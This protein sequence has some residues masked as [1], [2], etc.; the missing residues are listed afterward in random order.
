MSDRALLRLQR[1]LLEYIR[2]PD[3]Q[4][5]IKY[6]D[7]NI[8]KVRAL[9]VGPVNTP[10]AF[11]MFEFTM[12]FPPEYP[13]VPP[14]VKILTT[15][16]GQ[17]RFNPNFYANGKVCLSILGTWIGEAGEQWSSAHGI[18]SILLSIQSLMTETPY[19][20]EPGYGKDAKYTSHAFQHPQAQMSSNHTDA[21]KTNQTESVTTLPETTMLMVNDS[22]N[23]TASS[24]K[25]Q[26]NAVN[27]NN[28]NNNNTSTTSIM[29]PSSIQ[30]SH[31]NTIN[32][33]FDTAA[34]TA[35]GKSRHVKL[36]HAKFK[37][38]YN[39]KIT[40]ET[41]RISVCDRLEA[42]LGIHERYQVVKHVDNPVYRLSATSIET[43]NSMDT[44]S[45]SNNS[46]LNALL[47]HRA[48]VYTNEFSDICKRLFLWHANAYVST[49]VR[50]KQLIAPRTPFTTMP[51][52][53]SGNIMKGH[54]DYESLEKRLLRIKD[55]LL[56]E[57]NTWEEES[58]NWIR[59]ECSVGDNLR[60]QLQQIIN[61]Q[62]IE[63]MDISLE[64]D[65]PYIWYISIFGKP[66]TP[67]DDGI[68]RLKWVF[69]KDFPQVWPRAVFLTPVYHCHVTED[70]VPYYRVKRED[71]LK[72]HLQQIAALFT[73]DPSPNP[74]THVNSEAA[75]L[76]FGTAEERRQY[77]RSVRRCAARSV[78]Y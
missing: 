27:D 1:E 59:D 55:L 19:E 72:E 24:S 11:G 56:N 62:C 69:H 4:I 20:N 47:G 23:A 21:A 51:F 50:E 16:G 9:I 31:T 76:Y 64:D 66:L 25:D 61:S 33:I 15:D 49:C 60:G 26:S 63:G 10:Y 12:Q 43:V 74:S 28:N 14:L 73:E 6:R 13:S 65:N 38:E 32:S 37:E 46:V 34:V 57:A 41:I 75:A 3:D 52:E 70:G 17:T 53:G 78:E 58:R 7:D 48:G 71:D 39:R 40:H 29:S 35:P 22:S 68:F 45:N 44:T 30:L 8:T 67:Y 5:F 36:D 54:F 18:S 42:L 2:A 77:M